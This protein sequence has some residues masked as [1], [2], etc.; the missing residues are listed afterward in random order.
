MFGRQI[1]SKLPSVPVHAADS[2]TIRDTDRLRKEKGKNYSDK[3]RRAVASDIQV[4]DVVLAKRIKKDHKLQSNYSPE[5]FEVVKRTGSDVHIRSKSS[6][7][8]YRRNVSQL[9]KLPDQQG[10]MEDLPQEGIDL[11]SENGVDPNQLDNSELS[12]TEQSVSDEPVPEKHRRCEPT[13]FRDYVAHYLK[14]CYGEVVGT[15]SLATRPGPNGIREETF[16][17]D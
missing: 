4:G 8:E 16:I 14:D 7:K 12:D 5:E 1:K 17:R 15:E 6:G 13:K 9:K 11:R 2:D 10:D 3:I